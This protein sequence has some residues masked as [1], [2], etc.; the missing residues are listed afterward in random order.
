MTSL[1]LTLNEE[2]RLEIYVRRMFLD[3]QDSIVEKYLDPASGAH[4]RVTYTLLPTHE[5]SQ[6][7]K[8]EQMEWWQKRVNTVIFQSYLKRRA[9][10]S[11]HFQEAFDKYLSRGIFLRKIEFLDLKN[12]K[13]T[14]R[15]RRN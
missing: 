14:P 13:N 10:F 15:D 2:D 7:G 4:F 8:R 12:V 9:T 6:M 5:L 3:G 1:V 11:N